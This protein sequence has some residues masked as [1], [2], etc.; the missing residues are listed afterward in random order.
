MQTSSTFIPL[1]RVKLDG[2]TRSIDG[3]AKSHYGSKAKPLYILASDI[4]K[5]LTENTSM[6]IHFSF[7]KA[8]NLL[9]YIKGVGIGKLI[10]ELVPFTYILQRYRELPLSLLMISILV[11]VSQQHKGYDD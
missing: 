3:V 10:W 8:Q 11:V 5:M 2:L 4:R 6:S 1:F 9:M 7:P